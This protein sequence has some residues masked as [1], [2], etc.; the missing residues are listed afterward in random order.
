MN[1]RNTSNLLA[2][3]PHSLAPF[4]SVENEDKQDIRIFFYTYMTWNLNSIFKN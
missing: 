1:F 3:S 2:F 4:T